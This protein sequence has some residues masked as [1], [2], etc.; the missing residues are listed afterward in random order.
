MATASGI[1]G[2]PSPGAAPGARS[3]SSTGSVGM[4]VGGALVACAGSE[5]AG[6]AGAATPAACAGI[7]NTPVGSQRRYSPQSQ[8]SFP[9]ALVLPHVGQSL[10]IRGERGT[11]PLARVRARLRQTFPTLIDREPECP[12]R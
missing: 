6:V 2:G 3:T 9:S 1:V 10:A 8:K 12:L 11:A 4:G 7:A 5:G